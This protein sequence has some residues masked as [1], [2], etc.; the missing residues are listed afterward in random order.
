VYDATYGTGL[1]SFSVPA[2]FNAI[3]ST[4]AETVIGSTT[5]NQLQMLDVQSS[6]AA[7]TLVAPL[8]DPAAYTPPAGLSLLGGVTGLPASNQVYNTVAAPFNALQPLDKQL[9]F[10]NVATTSSR[11]LL[12]GGQDLFYKF[13]TTQQKAFT[14]NGA[15]VPIPAGNPD[16]TAV[17]LGSVDRSLAVNTVGTDKDGDPVPNTVNLFGQISFVGRGSIVLDYPNQ[18]SDLTESFRPDLAGNVLIDV[19]G[20]V[21]SIRGTDASGLVIND[22]G[23][24]N[25]VAFQRM[26]NSTIV[27][28]PVSHIHIQRRNNVSISS[29]ARTVGGRNGVTFVPNLQEIG[30]L[31]QTHNRPGKA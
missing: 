17:A 19:Q 26:T 11:P 1:G 23:N 21:Q 18:L 14:K 24:L 27:G 8:G 16:R 10:L 9:G 5:A 30:P 20:N 6:L 15:F 25:L 4:D 12:N 22:A 31:S 13:A 28:E 29:T 3:G 7:G 2:G